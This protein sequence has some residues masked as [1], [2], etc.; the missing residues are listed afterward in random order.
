M[1]ISTAV[2]ESGLPFANAWYNAMEDGSGWKASPEKDQPS[3]SPSPETPSPSRA[4]RLNL[5][6]AEDN[7]PDA[8]LVRE[9]IRKENL[10][11]DVHLVS[12]GQQAVDFIANSEHDDQAPCPH[13]LLLDL[14]LPKRDGFEVLRRLRQS[15]RCKHSAVL[16][17]TSSDSAADRSQAASLGAAYFRKPPNYQEFLKLGAILKQMMES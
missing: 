15:P 5:L 1:T 14:N 17:I 4:P 3:S 6:L 16:V 8:L 7:L 11:F 2:P 13:L 10:P 12:D 9:V